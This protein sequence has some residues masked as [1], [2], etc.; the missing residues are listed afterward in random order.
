MALSNDVVTRAVF[1]GKFSQQGEYLCEL[2]KAF[3]LLG[4]FCLIDLFPSSWLVRWL[5]NGERQMKKSCGRG[6]ERPLGTSHAVMWLVR[7]GMVHNL[8]PGSSSKRRK[9][10]R[11]RMRGLSAPL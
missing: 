9:R 4:G 8:V 7:G 3:K 1:G 5:S 6:G 10:R 11:R 2:D